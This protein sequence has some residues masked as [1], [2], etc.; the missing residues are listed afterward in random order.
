[1]TVNLN[2]N[3]LAYI[4]TGIKIKWENLLFYKLHII[5]ILSKSRLKI[6]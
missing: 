2:I 4:V 3:L 6:V 5:K 1:M